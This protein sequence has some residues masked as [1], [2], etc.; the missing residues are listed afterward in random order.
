MTNNER[1]N[2]FI[3]SCDNPRLVLE[4]LRALAPIIREARAAVVSR[5]TSCSQSTESDDRC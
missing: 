3:N 2:A 4:A 1:F 5:S